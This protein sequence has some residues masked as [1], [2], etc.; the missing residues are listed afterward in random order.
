[1][2]G[3][4]FGLHM[5]AVKSCP[6]PSGWGTPVSVFLMAFL[7]LLAPAAHAAPEQIL[8]PQ[9][10]R[11]G[12]GPEIMLLV[13]DDGRVW[14]WGVGAPGI[15]SDEPEP[16][17]FLGTSQNPKPDPAFLEQVVAVAAGHRLAYFLCTDGVLWAVGDNDGGR[18]GYPYPES[19]HNPMKITENVAHVAVFYDRTAIIKRD[20]TLWLWGR[21]SP[22]AKLLDNVQQVAQCFAYDFGHGLALMRDGSLMAWG[23]NEHGQL[24]DGSRE[25]RLKPVPVTIDF[26]DSPVVSLA[27]MHGLSVAVT[28][29]G[30][31]HQ[32]G[33]PT[34]VHDTK[35]TPNKTPILPTANV[36]TVAFGSETLVRKTDDTLWLCDGDKTPEQV[37][38]NVAEVSTS[39]HGTHLALKHDGSFWVWGNSKGYTLGVNAGGVRTQPARLHFIDRPESLDPA[40]RDL[41]ASK[42]ALPSVRGPE[43]LIEMSGDSGEC[44]VH[45]L[46]KGVLWERTNWGPKSHQF[47]K[48]SPQKNLEKFLYDRRLLSDWHSIFF[49]GN[50][51]MGK[52]KNNQGQLGDGTISDR[53]TP[54]PV[55]MPEGL[56][57]GPA[58]VNVLATA[59]GQSGMVMD[60][61]IWLWGRRGMVEDNNSP[62]GI[63]TPRP[64]AFAAGEVVDLALGEN[65]AL[66]LTKDG[67]LWATEPDS[68]P[69]IPH[70]ILTNVRSFASNGS[71]H[72]ALKKDGSLWGWGRNYSCELSDD[73]N[74]E[75][76][77]P[78]K[79]PWKFAK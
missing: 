57:I 76:P 72:V 13:R 58:R 65:S 68:G 70:K 4:S 30:K 50:T 19:T 17:R 52:G 46:R 36:R 45:I 71:T 31:L 27:V 20:S 9:R 51:L 26:G 75:F 24:G 66:F 11:V 22:P 16:L 55:R 59:Y 23:D 10:V 39:R 77:R 2:L 5:P 64:L 3:M 34:G 1:M 74:Q 35:Y 44:I 32:W 33:R 56:T 28:A 79:L 40:L 43:R 67:S 29:D 54:V 48:L 18:L 73:K 62:R 78:V 14:K 6:A 25:K 60:G 7:L 61:V 63:S 47:T 49:D 53:E 69:K 37:L 21:Y 12:A 38:D 41:V 15:Y 8:A 42:A